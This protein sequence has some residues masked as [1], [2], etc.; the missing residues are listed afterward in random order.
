MEGHHSRSCHVVR[1]GS[2]GREFLVLRCFCR[3]EQLVQSHQ[4]HDRRRH[5]S[6]LSEW[7]VD[8]CLS[9]FRGTEPGAHP[10]RVADGSGRLFPGEHPVLL[11]QAYPAWPHTTHKPQVLPRASFICH[12]SS[13]PKTAEGN[14]RQFKDLFFKLFK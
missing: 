8:G 12:F 10:R 9:V 2:S 5:Q 4:Q 11:D 13:I 3:V 7:P 14:P 1:T 6:E